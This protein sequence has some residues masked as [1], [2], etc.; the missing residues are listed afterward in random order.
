MNE[1]LFAYC[2]IGFHSP[3]GDYMG[4][5]GPDDDLWQRRSQVEQAHYATDCKPPWST[6]LGPA[7]IS[8]IRGKFITTRCGCG[9]R[10]TVRATEVHA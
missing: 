7:Q 4:K 2:G 3:A 10:F 5:G 8:G 9:A 1:N 6:V